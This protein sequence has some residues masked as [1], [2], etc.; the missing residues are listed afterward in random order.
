MI[1]RKRQIYRQRQDRY[2]DGLIWWEDTILRV[3]LER[4]KNA[5]L[6]YTP[7]LE[8]HNLIMGMLGYNGGRLER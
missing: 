2:R 6:D 1:H 7:G 4:E 5:I 8:H 3:T